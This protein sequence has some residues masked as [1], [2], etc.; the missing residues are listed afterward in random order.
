[1]EQKRN[2]TIRF[3]IGAIKYLPVNLMNIL[4]R[5]KESVNKVPYSSLI[6]VIVPLSTSPSFRVSV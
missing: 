2:I 4:Y 6:I 1:M 5:H 3:F